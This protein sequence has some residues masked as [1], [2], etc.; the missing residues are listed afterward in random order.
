[1]FSLLAFYAL[2]VVVISLSNQRLMSHQKNGVHK[3]LHALLYTYANFERHQLFEVGI[4]FF[5]KR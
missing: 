3:R 2:R 4:K 1:M 5:G